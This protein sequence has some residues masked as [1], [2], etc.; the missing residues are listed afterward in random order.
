MTTLREAEGTSAHFSSQALLGTALGRGGG[1]GNT[2]SLG[3][4]GGCVIPAEPFAIEA[5]KAAAAPALA[6]FVACAGAANTSA[7][8]EATTRAGGGTTGGLAPL[9]EELAAA[10]SSAG[11]GNSKSPGPSARR[12]SFISAGGNGQ[13][14]RARGQASTAAWEKRHRTSNKAKSRLPRWV[15]RRV[16]LHDLHAA[17]Q[18]ASEVGRA[19]LEHGPATCKR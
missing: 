9:V 17:G 12:N 1:R 13:L 18:L 4:G 15:V 6:A 3:G 2:G 7:L 14:R 8:T 5:A 16:Y 19:R 10:T 11:G